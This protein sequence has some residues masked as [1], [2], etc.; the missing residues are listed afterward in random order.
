MS[1]SCKV[2]PCGRKVFGHGYCNMHYK[3]WRKTGDP[4]PAES[5]YRTGCSVFSCEEPHAALGF[6]DTHYTRFRSSGEIPTTPIRRYGAKKPECSRK[7]CSIES[8]SKGL[9]SKHYSRAQLYRSYDPDFT[10][11]KYDKLWDAQ[12]GSCG[13]CEDDLVWDSKLTHV[14]HDHTLLKIRGLL[15]AT[16]NMGLGSFKDNVDKLQ[17]AVAYLTKSSL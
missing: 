16:C 10:W 17:K 4:G 6:C 15:C 3:R 5:I 9:C 13:I 2:A 14:D 11:D 12:D 8:L 1:K 7:F